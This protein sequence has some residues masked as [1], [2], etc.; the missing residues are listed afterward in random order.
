MERAI[1][2]NSEKLGKGYEARN[3]KLCTIIKAI[4]SGRRGGAVAT[5][6]SGEE[7]AE[8]RVRAQLAPVEQEHRVGREHAEEADREEQ[9]RYNDR[10][11]R[12]AASRPAAG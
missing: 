7:N 4:A 8:Q 2:L 12:C 1:N 11:R 9:R 6:A 10:A 3:A 5:S